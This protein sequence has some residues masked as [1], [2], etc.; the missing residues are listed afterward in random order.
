MQQTPYLDVYPISKLSEKSMARVEQL[1][2]T[3]AAALD[4]ASDFAFVR[5][6]SETHRQLAQ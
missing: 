3:G 1:L 6:D 5:T 2:L 4:S